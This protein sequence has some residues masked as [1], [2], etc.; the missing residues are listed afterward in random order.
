M[1]IA[2]VDPELRAATL[3]APKLN[4]ENPFMLKLVGV[5]SA[6]MPGK[7]V[8]GVERRIVR[9]GGLK[10]RVYV[11]DNPTGAGLLWIHGGGLVLGA[12]AMDD[13]L[14]GET[15]RQ[16]GVTV[17][18]VDYRLAPKHPFP[19]AID[20]CHA[21]WLWVHRH[22]DELGLDADRIAI[23]GQS[24][25]G[26]LAAS[27][28]Q[29]VHDEGGTIAAQ[30]LFCPMLDDRTA[31]DRALDG[32]DHFVWSNRSNLVG[33]SS[34]LGDATGAAALPPYAAAARREDLGG[35]PPT[36]MY[37]SD[38]ELFHDEDLAYA[39]RL[40]S[41]GVDTTLEIVSGAPHGFEA[42]AADSAL[43]RDIV[44]KARTWLGVQLAG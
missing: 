30:W 25:G 24:A 14:C 19:A 35:L 38:I 20:D 8:D 17:I 39:R 4:L 29:R 10:L 28:V 43:A 44:A 5:A 26:G 32:V 1:D 40:E 27:L 2:I 36:W 31:V 37:T 13:V 9:D 15:A 33:W 21:S 34:Y 12:A 7:R 42:W 6:I 41:A 3:K 22:L 23:G 16:T 11:P 18:S